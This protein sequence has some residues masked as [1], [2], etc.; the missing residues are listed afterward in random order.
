KS[1]DELKK[2]EHIVA[3]I[4]LVVM[5][6]DAERSDCVFKTL[7]K[8]RGIVGSLNSNVHHQ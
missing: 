1:F 3:F 8:F 5:V 6:F 2:L 7:N 4:S